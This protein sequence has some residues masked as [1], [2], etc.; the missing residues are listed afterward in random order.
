MGKNLLIVLLFCTFAA[1]CTGL[2]QI[3]PEAHVSTFKKL[4]PKSSHVEWERENGLIKVEFR[5]GRYEKEAWFLTDG[6]WVRTVTEIPY[7]EVP[8]AVVTAIQNRLGNGWTID[9]IDLVEQKDDPTRYY[10]AECEKK[11]G[12]QEVHL[13]ITPDG[14]IL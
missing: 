13:R 1:G 11:G 9:D 5:D 8:A 14:T 7:H 4:Y 10:L 12:K 2:E 6:T 3:Q